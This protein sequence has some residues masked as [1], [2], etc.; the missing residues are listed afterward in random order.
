MNIKPKIFI[1]L[2]ITA[3]DA[4]FDFLERVN[5]MLYTTTYKFDNY[6]F[7]SECLCFIVNYVMEYFMHR[8]RTMEKD[9]KNLT[10]IG[11]VMQLAVNAVN[12]IST[13]QNDFVNVIDSIQR[14]ICYVKNTFAM[15]NVREMLSGYFVDKKMTL[16]N[17]S[18][19]NKVD[20][21]NEIVDVLIKNLKSFEI[22]SLI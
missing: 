14:F 7:F 13:Q 12:N 16:L 2:F 20:Y 10:Y 22:N 9:V 11:K 15:K 6:Y 8:E 17:M 19:N 1:G 18:D 3:D 5:E 21:S 4:L